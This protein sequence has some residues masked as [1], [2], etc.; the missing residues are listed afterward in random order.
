[1]ARSIV[2]LRDMQGAQL[3][4][5]NKDSLTESVLALEDDG[6]SQ[7][8]LELMKISSDLAHLGQDIASPDSAIN[9]KLASM[10][11][12]QTSRQM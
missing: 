2:E 10:Q 3:N 9:I 7:L 8:H 4:R 5:M 12:K 1:M 6:I 11:A